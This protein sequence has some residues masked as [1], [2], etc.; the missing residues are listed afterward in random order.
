MKKILF[1]ASECVPFVSSGGLGDVIGSLPAALK[2]QYKNDADIRVVLPL[3][4]SMDEAYRAKAVKIGEIYVKLS[5]RNQYCGIFKLEKNGV[6]YYFLD[7]EYYFNRPTLYGHYDDGE[8]FAFFSKAVLEIMPTIDFYPDILHAHDWQTSLS[9]IYLK[10]K[11]GLIEHYCDIKTV[12]TIHNI[13]YQ[14]VYGFAIINDV[15]DLP[16]KDGA[17]LDYNGDINLMKGAI[18][19]AD[20]VSTVSPTYAK[21]ILSPKFSHGLHYVLEQNKSKLVGILNGIDREYYNPSKDDELFCNYSSRAIEK[22]YQNKVSLQK[23]LNL[24]E[25]PNTPILAVISRLVDHKGL[26]LLTLAADDILENDVQLII[27]GKGEYYYENFFFHLAE[28]YPNKV[29]TLL[30]YNRDLSKKIYSGS[31]MFIMP[32]RSEPC[33]L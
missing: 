26:D 7:N 28:R 11:Y 32:S 16:K 4:G 33:G 22:K 27:L 10:Y 18:V 30:T 31:D 3:Y 9:I 23:M 24:P 6:I 13:A 20:K 2:K 15:F 25:K 21:E 19:C 5:W 12:Y 1:V 8:R 17:I 14:G 29:S